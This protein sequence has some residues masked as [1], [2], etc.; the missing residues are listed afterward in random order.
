MGGI[1]RMDCDLLI[2]GSGFGGSV[3]ACRAAEAGLRVIV[4]ERGR[5][6]SPDVYED[7]AEGRVPIFH[8]D[9]KPGL[10]EL[11]RLKGLLALT[12]N[13]VGGGSNVYT[14]VTIR[15][16][17]EIFDDRWPGGLS[18][19]ALAPCY[20]RVEAMIAPTPVPGTLSRMRALEAVGGRMKT[21]VTRLPLSMDWPADAAA[22]GERPG[23]DGVYR[24]LSTWLRG[25]R[26]ARK[27]TLSQTYLAT[28]EQHGA[29]IRPLHEVS[30]IA[31]IGDD[32][33]IDYRRY[34][35]GVWGDG[36][37][38]ASCVVLAAGTLNTVRLLLNCRNELKTLPRLSAVLGRGFYTNGDF[39]GLLTAPAIELDPDAG[40][41]VTAW[42][43]RWQQDRLYLMETG[44]VPY[45]FGSFA[46][47]LN[48]ASWF[49]GMRLA[50]VKRT[51]WSFGVMGG[52][53]NPGRLEIGRRGALVHRHDAARG[54]DF[55]RRTM[56][57]LR[58]LADAA[59][60]KLLT[61]PAVL[62]R[63]LPIT[64]HPLGGAAMAESPEAGVTN[65]FGEVFGH[66]GLFIT[67]GSLL[68]VPTG[69][70]PSMTIAALA[71]YVIER[72]LR[73]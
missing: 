53:D 61:P 70:P 34:E 41:P 60:G 26:A 24:E 39:G 49:S 1:L 21:D 38:T 50:P 71:E 73:P 69:A 68:P 48:P 40:P 65:P 54:T 35:D 32:Y 33:R 22:L 64:V 42:I 14:A 28:A 47:L 13:A 23:T 2:I 27:R 25:G 58:E 59:G 67:D 17:A 45:D 37:L 10:M 5:R 36:V 4:L 46:G 55:F 56:V 9:G 16:P 29:E 51:T 8:G 63:R 66:P 30:T 57:A 62:A 18:F 11:H 31:P 72:M 20:D 3:A 19:E 44:L 43:D 6:M 12:A 15:P 7:M 52:C